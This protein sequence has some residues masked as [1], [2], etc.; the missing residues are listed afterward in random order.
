MVQ[1]D[2]RDESGDTALNLAMARGHRRMAEVQLRNG[3]N[4]NWANNEVLTPLHTTCSRHNDYHLVEIFFKS[5]DDIQQMIQI[6]AQH[7]LNGSPLHYALVY[8]N[9]II[10]NT[11]RHLCTLFARMAN[12]ITTKTT[13]MANFIRLRRRFDGVIHEDL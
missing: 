2:A 5:N 13:T 8:D 6:D 9:R 10:I 4:P 7:K 1:I 3:V 11:D 12:F